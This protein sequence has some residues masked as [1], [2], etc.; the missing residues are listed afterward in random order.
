M[1]CNDDSV[2]N[3]TL[4]FSLVLPNKTWEGLYLMI[5]VCETE[6]FQAQSE[7]VLQA[8]GMPRDTTPSRAVGSVTYLDRI[9]AM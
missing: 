1:I 7:W 4:S 2:H 3:H 6:R 9:D 5:V 8:A